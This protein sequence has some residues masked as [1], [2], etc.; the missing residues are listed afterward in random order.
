MLTIKVFVSSSVENV[1]DVAVCIKLSKNCL[2]YRCLYQ[3]L[4]KMLT[5][6]LF[7]SNSGENAYDIGVCIKLW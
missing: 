1:Y 2:R 3:V 5:I 4:V 7:V 6:S